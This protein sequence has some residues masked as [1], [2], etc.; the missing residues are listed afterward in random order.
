MANLERRG[1]DPGK[2]R[3]VPNGIVPAFWSADRVRPDVPGSAWRPDEIAV[4]YPAR[5]AWRTAWARC[6][7]RRGC[8]RS[9]FPRVRFFVVG[10]G[11]ERAGLQARAA[12][13]GL[14]NVAFTGLL[15]RSA[16]AD[17]MA[18]SDVTLV[19]LK[20]AETFKTVLPSKMFEA[21][22]AGKPIVLAVD[23]E[24]RR[25]LQC[26]QAGMFV[27]PGDGVALA[28][29]VA[30]LAQRNDLRERMGTAGAAY[31]VRE[32]NRTMSAD[33]YLAI[34]EGVSRGRSQ[35]PAFRSS[36]PIG[37]SPQRPL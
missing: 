29:A 3:Y 10:D 16:I 5:S 31:V 6:F 19:T 35:E 2:L 1:V 13:S 18:A 8:S 17:V 25:V 36:A 15:P 24:A 14:S 30:T 27:P 20:A 7:R 26:A 33:R 21:M 11:A 9:R 22:A 23:G 4:T 12:Q 28:R 34:L 32:F 37:N